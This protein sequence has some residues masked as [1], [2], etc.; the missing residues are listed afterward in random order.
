[1][2]EFILISFILDVSVWPLSHARDSEGVKG[3]VMWA[4]PVGFLSQRSSPGNGIV[5]SV[6]NASQDEPTLTAVQPHASLPSAQHVLMPKRQNS[7]RKANP[8]AQ[9]SHWTSF[10]TGWMRL[11]DLMPSSGTHA[12]NKLPL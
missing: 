3:N 4:F 5:S 8:H 11:A 9:S 12:R 1:M 10:A 6:R 2:H 7:D